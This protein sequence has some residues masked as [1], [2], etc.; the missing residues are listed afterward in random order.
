MIL[1]RAFYH[2]SKLNKMKYWQW[3]AWAGMYERE[4]A[5]AHQRGRDQETSKA[6]IEWNIQPG[7]LKERGSETGEKQ[8]QRN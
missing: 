4:T 2:T 8:R 1:E 7:C 5:A 6:A 3:D